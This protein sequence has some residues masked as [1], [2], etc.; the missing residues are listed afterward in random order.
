MEC[1]FTQIQEITPGFIIQREYI[2]GQNGAQA[3]LIVIT[4]IETIAS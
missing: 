1:N 3:S 4:C 2:I